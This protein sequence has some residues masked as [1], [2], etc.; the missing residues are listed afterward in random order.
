MSS[1]TAHAPGACFPW[2][3]SA[4]RTSDREEPTAGLPRCKVLPITVARPGFACRPPTNLL[5]PEQGD[6]GCPL[7]RGGR[8]GVFFPLSSHL[9]GFARCPPSGRAA[10]FRITFRGYRR[11]APR[12]ALRSERSERRR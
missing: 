11:G 12:R 3:L 1:R 8:G 7:K 9:K 5:G 4:P 2:F 6:V 10:L